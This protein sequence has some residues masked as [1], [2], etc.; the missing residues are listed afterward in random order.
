MFLLKDKS[1]MYVPL[2]RRQ[3]AVTVLSLPN[4]AIALDVRTQSC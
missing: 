2:S 4:I 3:R 1:N